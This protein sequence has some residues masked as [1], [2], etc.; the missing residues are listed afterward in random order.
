MAAST[1]VLPASSAQSHLGTRGH[2]SAKGNDDSSSPS[3]TL[4]RALTDQRSRGFAL[5]LSCVALAALVAAVIHAVR[6]RAGLDLRIYR[7]AVVSTFRDGLPLYGTVHEAEGLPFTYPPFAAVFLA[8]L[9]LVPVGVGVAAM[10]MACVV[11]AVT[12]YALV[13]S[14][15]PMSVAVR[16]QVGALIAAALI[17]DPFRLI[18]GLGQV[19]SVLALLVLADVF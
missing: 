9:A 19:D 18:L 10:F 11:L 8:P 4:L 13:D 15:V 16:T 1:K 2:A 17:T 14:H 12:V 6:D 3:R 7:D 5:A